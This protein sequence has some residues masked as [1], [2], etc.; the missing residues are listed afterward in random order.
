MR[1][2]YLFLVLIFFSCK[3]QNKIINKELK[4]CINSAYNNNV[5]NMYNSNLNLSFYSLMSSVEKILI[6]NKTI[7]N[8]GK[9]SYI[10]FF[11]KIKEEKE[12][13]KHEK[14]F[15]EIEKLLINE[16][17]DMTFSNLYAVFQSCPY[18]IITEEKNDANSTL[19]NQ[20]K[21]FSQMEAKGNDNLKLISELLNVTEKKYFEDI[22]YRAP[23]ILLAIINLEYL[24]NGK[25]QN[26]KLD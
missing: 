10:S 19:V 5:K 13:G 4:N 25:T 18:K 11:T 26:V 24:I 8:S 21:V 1:Y 15:H 12:I 17:F 3:T 2:K 7:K 20:Y 23:V 6:S 22:L 9:Q 16:K 14:V